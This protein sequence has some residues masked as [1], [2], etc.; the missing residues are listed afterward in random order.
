MTNSKSTRQ[1]DREHGTRRKPM[2]VLCL[3]MSRTGTL[4]LSQLG[5]T[6]YHMAIAMQNPRHSLGIGNEAMDAHYY[7]KG[8]RFTRRDFDAWIGD[9]DAVLDVP[10]VLLAE[11]LTAAYPDAKVIL[12]S[13]D[14]DGWVRS[15]RETILAVTSWRSWS[16]LRYLDPDVHE[17]MKAQ[18]TWAE[19]TDGWS[20]SALLRHEE[21]IRA[22]VPKEKL[23]EFRVG[24]DGWKELSTFLGTEVPEGEF[25]RVNDAKSGFFVSIHQQ[26]RNKAMMKILA[27]VA[28]GLLPIA[29]VGAGFWYS[30]KR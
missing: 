25:P 4:S 21:N 14:P 2:R 1:I 11:E 9:F 29:I 16:V 24:R 22:L 20:K 23:L 30:G 8:A 12:T 17:F 7:N 28:A 3:G 13:R 10:C 26:M 18:D 5:Y 15:C 27:K 19:V 6:P